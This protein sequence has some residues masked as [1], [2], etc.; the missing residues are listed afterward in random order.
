MKL[1]MSVTKKQVLLFLVFGLIPA[2]VIGFFALS[3]TGEIRQSQGTRLGEHAES[4]GDKIDR[5]LFERYGDVQAFGFNSVVFDRTQWYQP[6]S[7][8]VEAM[9]RY[10]A[11]YGVYPLMVL[12]DLEGKVIA[13][14][15]RDKDGHPIDSRRLYERNF[16]SARWFS[17]VAAAKSTTTQPH[18]APENH[19]AT[20]TF[21]EDLHKDDDV[22]TLY[23]GRDAMVLGFSAPVRDEHGTVIAYWK[24]YMAFDVIRDLV[25]DEVK[26]LAEDG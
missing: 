13:V 5:N 25:A 17:V 14:N 22:A 16:R 4:L 20:G 24:N 8:I 10:V 11:T 15:S 1:E 12:V 6:T 9:D 26:G 7:S 23:P 19:G 3:E 21:V 2:A 18:A